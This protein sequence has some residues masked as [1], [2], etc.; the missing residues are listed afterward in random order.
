MKVR[1]IKRRLYRRVVATACRLYDYLPRT[2]AIADYLGVNRVVDRVA[3]ERKR[4]KLKLV[5]S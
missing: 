4:N 5:K 2:A 3:A 1:A